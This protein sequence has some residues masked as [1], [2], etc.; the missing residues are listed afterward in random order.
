MPYAAFVLYL[1]IERTK[2]K[3]EKKELG[4]QNSIIAYSIIFFI[5]IQTAGLVLAVLELFVAVVVL[6]LLLAHLLLHWCQ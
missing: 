5:I 1:Q 3:K 4:K 6:L 2:I